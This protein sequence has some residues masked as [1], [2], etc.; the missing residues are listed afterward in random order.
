MIL[1]TDGVNN[2]G[3]IDPISAAKIAFKKGI[4][5]YTIGIGDKKGAPIPIH[6]PT[7]GKRYDRY[8]NGQ[9]VLTEFDDTVLKQIASI[10]NALYFNA[11][12]TEE[13]KKVYDQI[14]ELEKTKIETS[15]QY[16]IIEVFPYLIGLILLMLLIKE[17]IIIRSLIGV[18]T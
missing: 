4:K 12:N 7:Y 14:N 8:P 16:D 3:Q 2:A 6:H 9:L 1:I 5:V 18:K 13:L 15:K 10:T 11:T 17:W